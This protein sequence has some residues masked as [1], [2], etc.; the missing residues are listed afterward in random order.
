M[1]LPILFAP[2]CL[3][4]AAPA[5]ESADRAGPAAT[6]VREALSVTTVRRFVRLTGA[7]NAAEMRTMTFEGAEHLVVP[8]VALVGNAVVRPMHSTGP[9]FV[10]AEELALAPGGWDGR[11]VMPDHP[12][13]GTGSAN[14]PRTLERHRFG[15]L[16]G[17]RF[18]AGR[19]K[20]EAWLDVARAERLGG[21]ALRVVERCRAGEL[22]EVSVGCWVALEQVAGV[23]PDGTPYEFRWAAVTPDH[24]AMLPEGVEGA[25]SASMGCG[26]P[27]AAQAAP[28]INERR[29]A[30]RAA[31]QEAKPM[32]LPKRIFDA[33]ASSLGF[34]RAAED[35][36]P[37]NMDLEGALWA[38]VY[39]SEPAVQWIS[40][41]F[42]ESQTFIYATAPSVDAV[43]W[44]RR[45]YSV[46]EDGT[47]TL[48]DDAEQVE[49]VTRY[50][51]LA[52]AAAKP[53][54]DLV[55]QLV[56]GPSPFTEADGP[57]LAL[58]PLER[59]QALVTEWPADKSTDHP[60][61]ARAACGCQ[62]KGEG[63]AAP[64]PD[65]GVPMSTKVQD[66]V[67]RLIANAASPFTDDDKAHLEAL[68][69]AKLAALD[70]AFQPVEPEPEPEPAKKPDDDSERIS[71]DELA[72]LRAAAGAYKRQLAAQKT[73]LIAKLKGAQD[74]YSE[75]E[76][77]A[78]SVE[79]LEKVSKL[80]KVDATP[81]RDFSGRGF[82][83]T[84]DT[85]DESDFAPP[86]TYGLVA[87]AA[88]AKTAPTK[89][90]N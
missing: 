6:A 51:P 77:Q 54:R 80:A 76:L 18:E 86:D 10:P 58:A 70:A 81:E 48:G 17:T 69:E 72:D 44:W 1:A 21:D 36:G 85:A 61:V 41:V 64:A 89:E 71:K 57:M 2:A 52:A 20:T 13:D 66:L 16:F 55:A 5:D 74:A 7:A 50:E 34:R 79:Q 22:V 35:E 27:R 60:A 38:A 26:A 42:Q 14:E 3:F 65:E 28:E 19:L 9:E 90:A 83:A 75:A 33:M 47:V 29:A 30:M 73:A 67:G 56:S 68:C 43:L 88:K 87:A 15:Q 39:A 24:L 25:C 84:G 62:G 59:L 37:S 40:D 78:M 12:A 32:N 45:S 11:P 53:I 8:V 23:A 63:Q 31:G 46:A 49:P 4:E 82:P